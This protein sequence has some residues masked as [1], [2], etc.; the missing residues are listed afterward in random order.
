MDMQNPSPPRV[1]LAPGDEVADVGIPVTVIEPLDL[2]ADADGLLVLDR[3]GDVYRYDWATETWVV[4]WYMRPIGA[5]SSHYYVA[6]GRDGNARYLLETSYKFMVQYADSTQIALWPLPERR[7]VD[8]AVQA[9]AVFALMNEMD[10]TAGALTLYRD[11]ALIG[12]FAPTVAINQPRGLAMGQGSVFVLDENGRRL[13]KLGADDGL[14]QEIMQLPAGISAV[15]ITPESGATV[16]AGRDR[17]YFYDNPSQTTHIAG[18]AMLAAGQPHD[19]DW[20]AQINGF[21]S[22]IGPYVSNRD[23]QMP[24][25]PRHYR[26]GVHQGSDFYWARGTQIVAV[27]DGTVI[28]AVL[29]YVPPFPAAYYNWRVQ[30]H[31]LGYTSEEALDFYRGRQVWVQHDNGLISRYVHLSAI[32]YRIAEGERV[33]QGQPIGLI[34]NSGSPAALESDTE[35]AHLHFELWRGD[36]YIGQFLR[37]IE[38][39]EWIETILGVE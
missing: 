10:S 3:A 7:G 36:Y 20:L 4:E 34:G 35:D 17:L 24:G 19:V 11:T 27:A 32:D 33:L 18:E 26:L 23:L 29:D 12:S 14:V 39:R 28:R 38:A 37:P 9:G 6:L 2:V 25:A 5:T 31:E 15:A 13:L 1:L 21:A 30:S 22:P 8:V 16:L